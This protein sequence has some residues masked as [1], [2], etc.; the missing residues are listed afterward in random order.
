MTWMKILC[1]FV[2][3]SL[4]AASF[5]QAAEIKVLSGNGP[6]AA[7]RELCAQF[8][9][10]TGNTIDL[11]FGVKI[12]FAAGL[13]TSAKDS[14]PAKALVR[15]LTAPAAAVTLRAKGVDPI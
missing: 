1:A 13:A 3:V 12:G 8:E 11:R 14:E 4:G 10:A 15:F 2:V 5:S 6:K 7:V 9:K